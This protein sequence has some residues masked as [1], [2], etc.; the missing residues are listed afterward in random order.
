VIPFHYEIEYH[1]VDLIHAV[2]AGRVSVHLHHA[3]VNG[4]DVPATTTVGDEDDENVT[5]DASSSPPPPPLRIVLHTLELQ[6]VKAQLIFVSN[7]SDSDKNNT[8]N[9]E[10]DDDHHK[11]ANHSNRTTS[12]W[13]AEQFIYRPSEQTCELIF[14]NISSSAT[15]IPTNINNHHSTIASPSSSH[16]HD[17]DDYYILQ[18]DF[19]GILNSHMQGLYKSTYKSVFDPSVVHAMASTQFEPTAARRAFPCFDE[20]ALKATFR[21]TVTIPPY[22]QAIS[23]TPIASSH[24]K[25][26]I[27]SS[28]TSLTNTPPTTNTT[29]TNLV[30]TIT[31]ETTPIM[32]TYLVALVVGEFD[33]TSRSVH[34][35]RTSVYTVPGKA[36]QAEFC[37][38]VA[39]QCLDWYQTLFGIPY[40]L[41]KSDLVAIP[42]FASGAMEN[43]GCVTYREAKV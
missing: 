39:A 32:S 18:M 29:T 24:T 19:T 38:H 31:F 4:T 42:E 20:P 13:D 14:S 11:K 34:G 8:A 36:H 22:Y 43:W 28:T 30:K 27:A 21:L 16:S 41:E 23:N 17:D 7:N 1:N 6:I 5:S 12:C 15:S 10:D 37:L 26:M 40:P 3:A 2:F 35:I 33:V 25:M 9:N